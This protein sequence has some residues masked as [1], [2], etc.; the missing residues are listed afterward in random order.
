MQRLRD[1]GVAYAK[2]PLTGRRHPADDGKTYTLVNYLVQGAAAELL[3][4][5][6]IELDNA[7]FGPYMCL[8]IHDEVVFDVPA[9]QVNE[10]AK[11][12]CEVMADANLLTVPIT[13]G[14]ST[15]LR[16]GMK[17]DYVIA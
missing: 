3:K 2:S 6:L 1:E 5:K 4:M 14:P 8:P 12:A 17:E 9:N 7:G 16:W 13:V 15:G 10:F 11:A